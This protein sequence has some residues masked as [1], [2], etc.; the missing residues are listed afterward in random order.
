MGTGSGMGIR[1]Q[2]ALETYNRVNSFELRQ[3]L[4]TPRNQ[5]CM[6]QLPQNTF[7]RFFRLYTNP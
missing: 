3:R 1:Q 4:D 6:L 2:A 7:A 5:I